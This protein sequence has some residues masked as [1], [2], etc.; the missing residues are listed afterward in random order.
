MINIIP[1]RPTGALP[2][3]RPARPHH[4]PRGSPG[5][6]TVTLT[7]QLLKHALRYTHYTCMYVSI[8]LSLSLY[9]YIYIYMYLVGRDNDPDVV[10]V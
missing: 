4:G 3:L 5:T 8:S 7:M 9:L 2:D 6:Q 1:S 10:F